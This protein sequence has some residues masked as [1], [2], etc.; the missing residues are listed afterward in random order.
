MFRDVLDLEQALYLESIGEITILDPSNNINHHSHSQYWKNNYSTL[1]SKFRHVDTSKFLTFV[2]AS[3]IIEI[4]I[5]ENEWEFV[6]GI[7]NIDIQ[8]KIKDN[9]EYVYVL[10]NPGYPSVS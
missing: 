7:E 2:R 3:Y 5:S 4:P 1:R 8:S 9:I 6:Y 10:T